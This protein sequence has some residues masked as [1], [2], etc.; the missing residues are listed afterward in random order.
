M[1]PNTVS[2]MPSLGH[3]Q[4][5]GGELDRAYPALRVMQPPSCR[6]WA[7]VLTIVDRVGAPGIG[8]VD[9]H[10]QY[11]ENHGPLP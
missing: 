10:H 11:C 7:S 5:P 9:S 6:S 2:P 1:P 8:V 3:P 4:L